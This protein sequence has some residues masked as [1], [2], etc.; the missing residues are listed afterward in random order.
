ALAVLALLF[1]GGEVL[2]GF[3]NAMLWGIVIGTYYSLF[4]AAPLLYYVQPNRRAITRERETED[5][6]PERASRWRPRD[7]RRRKPDRHGTDRG[8][9][10]RAADHRAL[11]GERVP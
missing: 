5:A 3:S 11:R 9:P 10:D 4:I 1:L 6:A 2:R 8:K 7:W